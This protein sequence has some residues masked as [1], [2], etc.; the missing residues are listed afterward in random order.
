MTNYFVVVLKLYLYENRRHM[1][2][3]QITQF[4]Y[5]RLW[6]RN[7]RQAVNMEKSDI[8]NF[9]FLCIINNLYGC[10]NIPKFYGYNQS[11]EVMGSFRILY[12]LH[13][14]L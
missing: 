7:A 9:I 14:S 2:V 1:S 8:F 4:I 10:R 6:Y 5:G 3:F 13:G 11:M 12:M